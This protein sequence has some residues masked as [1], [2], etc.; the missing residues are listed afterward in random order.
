MRIFILLV[1]TFLSATALSFSDTIHVPGDQ[2]TIQ[3][4]IEA[5]TAGDLVLVAPGTYVEEIKFLGKAITVRSTMGPKATVID[6]NHAWNPVTF[7]DNESFDSVLDGFTVQ[8]GKSSGLGGG[9]QCY[10]ASPTITHN[11]IKDNWAY[12]HL[13]MGGGIM[14]V[15]ISSPIIESNII[16]DNETSRG[17][18]IYCSWGSKA[19]IASNLFYGNNADQGGAIYLAAGAN[20]VITHNTIVSNIAGMYEGAAICCYDCTT[21]VTNTICWNNAPAG[22]NEICLEFNANLE[23]KHCDI[24]GGESSIG[25]YSGSTYTW[26]PGM[27]D[28]DPL[29]AETDLHDYHLFYDSPCKDTGDNTAPGLPMI[30]YDGDPRRAYGTVDIGA[31][32][33]YPH[34][35]YTG[36]PM[37]NGLIKVKFV[38]LPGTT[39]VGIFIG[40]GIMD[41]PIKT[42]W[43]DFY[44]KAPW[45][46]I[47][48]LGPVPANGVKILAGYIPTSPPAPYEVPLQALIGSKKDSF[49][50]LSI[51]VVR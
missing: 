27:I 7:M 41:P 48:L 5:A 47:R 15:N 21:K 9:I 39:P 19:R 46:L 36:D 13:A 38:G 37:P 11:I 31:D 17:A 23:I 34:L 20:T 2:P 51:L 22:G 50:N 30:D 40:S 33:F 6:G 14:C 1:A 4:A 45:I 24:S 10:S 16:C 43:G 49:S 18:G 32:E 26:G 35:Y 25:A 3:Q 28:A 29:F 44:L 12:G 42:M 8:H